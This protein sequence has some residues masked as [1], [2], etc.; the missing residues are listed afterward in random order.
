MDEKPK[1]VDLSRHEYRADGIKGDPFFGSGWPVGLAAL[2]AII[3]GTVAVHAFDL[4][5][6]I[7][8]AL[9]GVLGYL[10]GHVH[11]ELAEPPQD[12]Q[13]PRDQAGP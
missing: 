10:I 11:S 2:F 7:G 5:A 3:G 13:P 8:S 6:G 9:G 1:T 4:P 12:R